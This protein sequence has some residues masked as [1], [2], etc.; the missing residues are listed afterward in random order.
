MKVA[1]HADDRLKQRT[2]LSP[3][4]L[5]R[6]RKTIRKKSFPA[7]VSHVP[8]R[9]G[10]GTTQGYAVLKPANGTHVVATVLSKTMKPPGPNVE[11]I[12]G[13]AKADARKDFGAV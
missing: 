2:P 3:D 13:L 10:H 1:A 8:L 9:D 6:L 11:Q 5:H 7:G 12:V 4:V